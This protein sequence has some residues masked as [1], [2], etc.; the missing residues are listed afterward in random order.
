MEIFPKVEGEGLHLPISKKAE[1]WSRN[2]KEL[3]KSQDIHFPLIS[4]SITAFRPYKYK[5]FM[6]ALFY[7]F[8]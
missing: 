3:K 8:A 5:V 4:K 6:V 7:N 1:I 2:N